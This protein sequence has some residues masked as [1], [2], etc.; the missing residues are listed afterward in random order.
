MKKKDPFHAREAASYEH[1]V[2]SREFISTYLEDVDVPQTFQEVFNGFEL[3]ESQMEGLRRRLRAMERDG[4]LIQNRRGSYALVKEMDVVRGPIQT[5][6]DGFGFLLADDGKGDIFL[7][8]RQVRGLFTDDVVLVRVVRVNN[9]G[10]REG[11]VI[12]VLERNTHELV[13]RIVIEDGIGFVTPDSNV[14]NQDLIVAEHDLNDAKNH[15]F[16]VV[17]ILPQ[18]DKKRQLKGRVLQVLGNQLTAGLE[19]DLA[20][21][22]HEIP[23][24]WSEAVFKE[25][26]K[27]P[28]VVGKR[29]C[30]GR[31][32]LRHLPFVTI[33]GEDAR[34]FDDAVYCEPLD[35]G[36]RVYV[37][38]ADVSHYVGYK[39]AINL[40]AQDRGNSVYFP[41]RVIPML[42]EALSNEL[43]SLKP[44]EDRLAMVCEIEVRAS[45]RA[46]SYQFYEGVIHSHARLT[47]TQVMDTINGGDAI[48][49]TVIPHVKELYQLYKKLFR[50]RQLRGAIDFDTTESRI[51][52]G[53]HG[54]ID[55]IVATSR[56]EAHRLIEELMLLANSCAAGF[57]LQKDALILYRNHEVPDEQKL[58][59]LRDFMK[60]FGL[61]LTGAK[62]PAAMDY[63]K[64]LE[65]IVKR[66]DAHLL[67]TVLLRSLKQ[68]RFE[69][70]NKGH[71]GLA[72][73][74]YCQFT[75]PIRRYPDLLVHRCIKNA[76]K[77][78][79]YKK[80]PYDV[81]KMQH[82][83]EHF[84]MTERRADRATREATD[85]L[86]CD[87]M[88]DKLGQEFSGVI[89][90]VVGFG[91][92][93]ELDDVFVEGLVHINNLDDDYYHFDSAHHL[94]RAKRSGKVYRLGD[95]V[96]V[97]VARVDLDNRKMDFDI[98]VK[99]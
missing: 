97:M 75:S 53:D 19:V 35:D 8:A 98:V 51:I 13:G 29:E 32:D 50:Q 38:I 85:W 65:R 46:E 74:G 55:R 83:G 7:P 21:R 69:T 81:E 96:H 72:Y 67:Q 15:D 63:C 54:K 33:D 57:L 14:M 6:R 52:F 94:L 93:V 48:P 39:S 47:Y 24:E 16:V 90:D 59:A 95:P 91:M 49:S 87:Y 86:K 31:T 73:E 2:P 28:T 84:S 80:Y 56:N 82:L 79:G 70:E 27:L 68:A 20:I 36:W 45:G 34:D 9:R 5:H 76:M 40:E 26:K 41:S 78:K 88:K 22:S 62:E 60:V 64:L 1:P 43:C 4:Q 66:P 89:S 42:P 3:E 25:T 58:E 37:A 71:F 10:R 44:D 17:S 11:V 18:G 23:F 61:R 12:E 77:V 30:K 92:F 99:K